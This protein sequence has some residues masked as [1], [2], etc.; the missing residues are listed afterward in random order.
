[1]QFPGFTQQ[2]IDTGEV[3]INCVT[4]GS[5][6][7]LLLLHGFPQTHVMWHN[8]APE[9]AKSFTVIC[10]DLRGY[11]DSDKPVGDDAHLA[12]SKKAMAADMLALM[13]ALGHETFQV[14]SHDRGARVAHRMG[15][16]APERITRLSI[17]DIVPTTEIYA[18]TN[19]AI[20]TAYYHWFFLIQPAPLPERLIGG[21]P[22]FYLHRTLGG[23]G[24]GGA[25]FYAP[26]ALAE[27]ERCFQPA[28]AIHAMCEDYRAGATIDLEHDTED[29]DRLI[30]CPLQLLWG[31]NGVIGSNFDVL[32]CWRRFAAGEV[33]GRGLDAGHFMAEEGPEEVLRELLDFHRP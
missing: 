25:S 1:M 29:A 3:S 15:R 2:R 32:D 7:A 14:I 27:Y 22:L 23:W 33:T 17:L 26:Q 18:E 5:G 13:S 4:G 20:A 8:Q 11:G 9:L 19:K 31:A 6:P 24:S 10:P 12:Y 16:D 30:Q 28:E 21:D